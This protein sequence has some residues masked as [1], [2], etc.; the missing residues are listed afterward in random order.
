M[1]ERCAALDV[2]KKTVTACTRWTQANGKVKSEVQTFGTTTPELLEMMDWLS[3]WEVTTV[4]IES[5]GEYWKPVFNLL[6]GNFE[7]L[8]V[9]AKHVKQVP[10]RK[11]DVKDAEWLAELLSYGLLKA[12]YIP[13]KP[14]RD[15]RDLTRHR[16]KLVQERAR[17]VNR[18]Q[19]VLEH[20]NIKLACV[21]TDV[22]GVSGRE[23]LAA[24]VDGETD[25]AVAKG[26]LR[27]KMEALEKALTGVVRP[28]HRFMLAQ[29]LA[30]IDFLDEQIET[31]NR[32]IGQ[33]IEGM[34]RPSEPGDSPSSG[35]GSPR[36]NETLTWAKSVELL[37]SAPGVDKR[38]AEI[39]LAEMGIDISQFKTADHLTAWAGLAPGNNQSGSKRRK[40]KTR[41]GNR[42]LREIM[43]QIAWAAS[44]KRGSYAQALYRRL[45]GRRGKKRAII[46]VA[47]TLLE[48]FWYMLSRQEPC[49]EL[50]GDYFDQRR[51]E[52]KVNVLT[53][54][55]EKLGYAVQ[56]ETVK[57]Q[58]EP[59]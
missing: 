18:L 39:V 52:V 27:N 21:A 5:T 47:R 33:R 3:D 30:H 57:L 55:L 58:L 43:V 54:Q 42:T 40:A 10:G 59:A 17:I 15:L 29:H 20:A 32:E 26:R 2:H 7:V 53:K 11:T 1:Y 46:A 38:A 16:V 49:K 19:K 4:A 23:M 35:D 34:S 37:D 56:L 9:N 36:V 41:E 24:L 44:R 8:L 13:A 14:Q 6:E 22:M 31:V 50:G 45:A 12:S 48:S 28:H 51:K 25:A